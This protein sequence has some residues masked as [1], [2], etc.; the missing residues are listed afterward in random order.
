MKDIIKK[1]KTKEHFIYIMRK[2]KRFI[3]PEFKLKW[4]YIRNVV[5]GKVKT[6]SIKDVIPAYIPKCRKLTLKMLMNACLQHDKLKEYIPV[7]H[8]KNFTYN[9][10]WLFALI[11]NLFSLHNIFYSANRIVYNYKLAI[12]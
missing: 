5:S 9:R 3:P 10:A 1:V 11:S 8:S 7:G 2:M 12:I 4:L 6:L